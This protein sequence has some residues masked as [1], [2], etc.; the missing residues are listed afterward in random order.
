MKSDEC[1]KGFVRYQERRRQLHSTMLQL[2]DEGLSALQISEELNSPV[3]T[4]REIL[5][6]NGRKLDWSRRKN[7]QGGNNAT[8]GGQ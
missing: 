4:V 1:K 8:T 5:R 3:Y 6:K 7:R 2:F